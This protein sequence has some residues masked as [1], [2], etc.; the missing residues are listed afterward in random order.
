M[1][2]KLIKYRTPV[3]PSAA[4]PVV[5]PEPRFDQPGLVALIVGPTIGFALAAMLVISLALALDG[6][7][8]AAAI[9]AGHPTSPT[10]TAVFI[11]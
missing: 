10:R 11:L 6:G 4:V 7:A 1:A 8:G 5:A 3:V 9:G 2:E